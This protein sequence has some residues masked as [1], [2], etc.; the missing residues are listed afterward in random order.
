[1][2]FK[3]N[4]QSSD[5]E[6]DFEDDEPDNKFKTSSAVNTSDDSSCLGISSQG[7]DSQQHNC[8][9]HFRFKTLSPT[10][11]CVIS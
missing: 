11:S 10:P 9:L 7:S 2:F 1:M 5:S 6:D 4:L 3:L 8:D